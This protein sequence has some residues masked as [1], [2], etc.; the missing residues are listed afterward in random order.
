MTADALGALYAQPLRAD[1]RGPLYNAFSYPTKISA[2]SVALCIALHTEPGDRVLDA[3]GGSGTTGIAAL[4]CGR[5]TPRMLAMAAALGVEPKW[6]PR[7][8]VVY[9]ISEIGSLL[10]R[11]MTNPPD[12]EAFAAAATHLVG[13]AESQETELYHATGPDGEPGVIRHIIWSDLVA[14]PACDAVTT[15]ADVRVRYRPLRFTQQNVCGCGYLGHPDDWMRLTEE[16]VDRWTG[17]VTSRR[18]RKPWRVYGQ[19]AGRKW[20]R[21]A[22]AADSQAEADSAGRPLPSSAPRARLTWG[23]LYRSGYHLG[24]THLHDLYSARNYRAVA[25]LWEAIESEPAE[26]R[27]ALRLLVLSYNSAHSTL[28]TRVVLKKASTDFVLTGAQSG[29][30]YVSGLPV[31]KNVFS[32]VRRKINVFRDAFQLLY[33]AEGEIDVVTASS[34]RLDL[35]D[36]SVD[37]VFT[38][39]PF[40][41]N[42]PYSEVN[43]INELWLGKRTDIVDEA[44]ISPAQSKGLDAY[45]NLLTRVFSEV[46]R[47]MKT[48]AE[49]TVVFHSAHASVWQALADAL[50]DAGLTVVSASVLD[51]TQASF[52][53]VNGHVAVSGD[54]LLRLRRESAE[55]R[56]SGEA[57]EH[58]TRTIDELLQDLGLDNSPEHDDVARQN[59]RLYSRVVGRALVAGAPVT[60][61]AKHFY[62]ARSGDSGR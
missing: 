8:A 59:R 15:Y 32:G 43:Q 23:D 33:G 24:M 30:L 36:K 56:E 27:D 11:V 40:G 21:P 19:S 50:K 2:E 49:A 17:T 26:V 38:D 5:P 1:R 7:N 9:E 14:C 28:M 16:S 42:I 25:T 13:S 44:I 39:P 52:K 4:L 31:E 61:D 22:L 18:L 48:N 54:P 53:Q 34:S 60:V 20:S 29:I 57:T 45:R 6:G 41:A 37:Y 62:A 55:A 3:F 10:A 35:P 58:H 12:P 47:V 46:G 51:K